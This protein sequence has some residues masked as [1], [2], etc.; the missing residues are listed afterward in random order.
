MNI[1][2]T[3]HVAISTQYPVLPVCTGHGRF[4]TLVWLCAMHEALRLAKGNSIY[5]LFPNFTPYFKMYKVKQNNSYNPPLKIPHYSLPG[6]SLSQTW[7]DA[8][9]VGCGGL[10][11]PCLPQ[12]VDYS[13][14]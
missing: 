2:K 11:P 3:T 6:K 1:S 5:Y 9:L 12:P 4:G 8:V 7:L 13:L 14:G 10:K